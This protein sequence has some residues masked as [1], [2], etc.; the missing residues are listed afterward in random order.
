MVFHSNF[1]YAYFADK[2]IPCFTKKITKNYGK[3]SK[4]V[5]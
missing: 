2:F 5:D 4:K 3:N 1:I